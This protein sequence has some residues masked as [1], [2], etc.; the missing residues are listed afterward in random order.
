[1]S[2]AAGEIVAPESESEVRAIVAEAAAN[3]TRLAVSGGVEPVAEDRLTLSLAALDEVVEHAAGDQTFTCAAGCRLATLDA[4]AATRRQRIGLEPSVRHLTTVGGTVAGAREGF[5]AARFG[6]VRDQVLGLRVV[7]PA[8]ELATFG[9]RVVKNVTGYDGVRLF[10]GSR[11]RLGIITQTTLRL[12]PVPVATLTLVVERGSAAEAVDAALRLR[13]APTSHSGLVAA[14]GTAVADGHGPWLAAVRYEGS[15]GAL[16]D[17]ARGAR[18]TLGE[19]HVLDE[20][21]ALEQWRGLTDLGAAGSWVTR[22]RSRPSRLALDVEHLEAT[23]KA[24]TGC[25]LDVG[26]GGLTFVLPEPCDA[27]AAAV[28]ELS[29]AAGAANDVITRR[30]TERLDPAG[31][32]SA[33]VAPA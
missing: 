21:D 14:G 15:D 10:T 18:S 23:A 24:P 11:G 3:G 1:M 6:P 13:T 33:G 5:I 7:T 22:I 9:G 19:V 26:T 28:A 20:D 25:V 16:D 27:V 30:L 2:A 32:L 29:P 8:G 12:R 31:I 4:A 17:A